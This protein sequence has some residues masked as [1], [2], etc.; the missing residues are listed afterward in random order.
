[1]PNRDDADRRLV[2]V[3]VY[4]E[5][6]EQLFRGDLAV[7][8]RLPDDIRLESAYHDHARDSYYF[9]FS[10]PSFDRVEEGD[11]IPEHEPEVRLL[12][13]PSALADSPAVER[14]DAVIF[15]AEE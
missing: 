6:V 15:D 11:V 2:R 1:M 9:V 5:W 4:R 13:D 8:K 7:L 14:G 10:S 12:D 3:P